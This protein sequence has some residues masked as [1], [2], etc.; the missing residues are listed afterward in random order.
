MIEHKT[1]KSDNELKVP[2][3]E[4]RLIKSFHPEFSRKQAIESN[5]YMIGW[6]ELM[7]VV[8]RIERLYSKNF[9]PD[10]V[11]QLLAGKKEI[12]DHHYM[13]VVAIPLATP[14]SEVYENVVTFVKWYNTQNS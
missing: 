1:E 14:I 10:F 7:P 12:I 2:V 13:D 11:Q 9:P 5:D 8:Q 3:G 4:F 6:S